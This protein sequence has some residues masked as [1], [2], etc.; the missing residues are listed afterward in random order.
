M[1]K[2]N[3]GESVDDFVTQ[4]KKLAKIAKIGVNE[5]GTNTI[6]DA[7]V[8]G[9]RPAVR[10]HVLQSGAD[11]LDKLLKAARVAE[12]AEVPATTNEPVLN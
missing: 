7:V 6:Y 4:V 12:V 11:T 9:L 5:T 2:Q 8:Q 10:S 1:R 3:P